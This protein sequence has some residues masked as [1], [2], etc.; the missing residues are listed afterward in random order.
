MGF[1]CLRVGLLA[2]LSGMSRT[3]TEKAKLV[4]EMA[5]LFLLSKFAVFP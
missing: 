5:L 4:V 1:G 2:I 3:T